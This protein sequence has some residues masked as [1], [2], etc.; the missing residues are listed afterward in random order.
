LDELIAHKQQ[1]EALKEKD[2]KREQLKQTI[3]T[4][5]LTGSYI[6]P[7]LDNYIATYYSADYTKEGEL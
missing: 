2:K 4:G 5:R 3:N 7:A 6:E 1:E